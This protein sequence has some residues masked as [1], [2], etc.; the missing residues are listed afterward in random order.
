MSKLALKGIYQNGHVTI[1]GHVVTDQ[2]VPVVINFLADNL[3]ESAEPLLQTLSFKKAQELSASIRTS[4]ADAL[5]EERRA[6]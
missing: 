3:A 2:A 1:E 6:E 5:I 4:L